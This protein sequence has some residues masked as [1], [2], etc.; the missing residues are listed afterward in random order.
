MPHN[1]VASTLATP[2]F[3]TSPRETVDPA[4]TAKLNGS[5]VRPAAKGDSP[6]FSCRTSVAS[7][8]AEDR[9]PAKKLRDTAAD[10]KPQSTGDCTGRTPRSQCAAAM[11]FLRRGI[12]QQS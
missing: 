11:T 5:R 2:S 9:G 6:S 7:T 4:T 10:Q 12:Q 1:P 8:A 3:S